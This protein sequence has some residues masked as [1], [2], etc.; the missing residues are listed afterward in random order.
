MNVL[1]IT[2]SSEHGSNMRLARRCERIVVR[3]R[4]KYVETINASELTNQKIKD[5]DLQIWIV[6]EWN[7]SFPFIF[8][9][10]I[11]D[12]EYP[13]SFEKKDILLIGTSETTFGNLI[14]ISHL[15][16]ILQWIGARVFEKR[17]CF[18]HLRTKMDT[19]SIS[20]EEDERLT[21]AICKFIC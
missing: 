2:Q 16:H 12:S 19:D 18:P 13:S 5:S 8:K 20:I 6:P 3:E 1:I 15:E 14:G 10:I 11:D 21:D 7:G 17:I 9:K 4:T